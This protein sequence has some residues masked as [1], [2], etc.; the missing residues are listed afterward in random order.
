MP[1]RS[2][3]TRFAPTSRRWQ[4]STGSSVTKKNR[5]NNDIKN[6]N[7]RNQMPSRAAGRTDVSNVALLPGKSLAHL[8]ED[9]VCF[10][11]MRRGKTSSRLPSQHPTHLLQPC[12]L[13]LSTCMAFATV[14]PKPRKVTIPEQKGI[15][16]S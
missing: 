11:Q 1:V 13:Y 10:I 16:R 15:S 2:S 9:P 12:R 5:I 7:D 8:L 14:L 4:E 3:S 6:A